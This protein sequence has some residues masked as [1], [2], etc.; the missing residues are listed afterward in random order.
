[1]NKDISEGHVQPVLD[2]EVPSGSSW[3]LPPFVVTHKRKLTPRLV[4][5]AAVEFQGISLNT[6][7]LS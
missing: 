6:L 3:Y 4:F 1:M 2:E 5:D 7:L